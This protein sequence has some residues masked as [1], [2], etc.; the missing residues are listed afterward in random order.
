VKKNEPIQWGILTTGRIAGI[1]AK[2]LRSSKTGR[3][4]AVASR[5]LGQAEKFARLH[6]IP[7]AYGNY[8]DLLKD[9]LVEALY[10]APP[11]PMHAEW[12]LKAAKAGKHIL[13]EKPLTMDYKD[14]L[15]VVEA[16]RRNRV[17]L[18]EAFMYRCHP[19]T[20]KLVELIREKT[21]GEVRL[22]QAA[23]CYEAPVDIKNRLFN[24]R[25]GGG[26][27]LDVG[28]YPVSMSRLI[29]GAAR[30]LPFAEPV[31]IKGTAVI[32]RKSRVDEI[33]LASLKFPGGVLAELSCGIRVNRGKSMVKIDGSG[34][35]L[36][37]PSPWF[38]KW[39]A[40]TSWIF[41]QKHGEKMPRKIPI[42]CDRNLYTVEADKV[43]EAVRAGNRESPCMTWAD[44]LGNMKVLDQW[45]KSAGTA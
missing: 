42:Y 5:T 43:A 8:A 39:D 13:C 9:P 11:H 29:A 23:F 30:G 10:I 17:F 44:T 19:Q 32:G 35:S 6:K 18:M 15:A 24:P 26:G 4:A 28:C 16:A 1:F 20:A 38:A 3:L 25:L 21:I 2:G 22:I 12:A 34:G 7:K 31:E 41:L 27:I 36:T 40:G 37:V 14:S 33:A 45:R